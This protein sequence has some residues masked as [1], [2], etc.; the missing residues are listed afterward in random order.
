VR[1]YDFKPAEELVWAALVASAVAV[2]QIIVT[3]DIAAIIDWRAWTIALVAAAVRAATAAVL[4][5]LPAPS[6]SASKP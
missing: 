1:R 5:R 6:A 3:A 4:A 2:L